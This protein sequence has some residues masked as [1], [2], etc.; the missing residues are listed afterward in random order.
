MQG[1]RPPATAAAGV[2]VEEG[3]ERVDGQGVAADV[4][5][6]DA[7]P[8]PPGDD[9]LAHRGGQQE[10]PLEDEAAHHEDAK[11][12]LV[13]PDQ[14]SLLVLFLFWFLFDLIK[15]ARSIRSCV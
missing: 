15:Q 2:A 9:V 13:P 4:G 6:P 10:E 12:P 14:P 11:L 3:G 7:R 5:Q 8:E 1:S